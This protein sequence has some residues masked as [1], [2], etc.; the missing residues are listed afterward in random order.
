MLFGSSG[1][2]GSSLAL[3]LN[4]REIIKLQWSEEGSFLGKVLSTLEPGKNYDLVF[5]G[6][7]TDPKLPQDRIAYSNTLFPEKIIEATGDRP[8]IRYLT[9]G[10][11]MENFPKACESNPYLRS[12][13]ELGRW[14]IEKS[15]QPQLA[16]RIRHVRLHTIYGGNERRFIKPH[17][18]LGQIAASLEA[19]KEFQMSSGDQLREY[20]HADDIAGSLAALLHREWPSQEMPILEISSGTPV[21]LGHLAR[22]IFRA[23]GKES[24]LKI[25][26]IPRAQGENLDQVFK[27]SEP[28]LLPSS[29]EPI[30]G[31]IEWF[32]AILKC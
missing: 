24:L 19:K 17:M 32:S 25:G 8:G 7:V 16:G 23:F 20:H 4:Q 9:L 15:K 27:R 11:V 10:T 3:E 13:L 26:A 12:K 1:Q 18:F 30:A 28:W 14:L 6:G 21:R 2:I 31:V 5:A 29:R 22:E